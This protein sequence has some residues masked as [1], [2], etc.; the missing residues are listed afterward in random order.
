MSHRS[1][2]PLEVDRVPGAWKL[3]EAPSAVVVVMTAVPVPTLLI[4]KMYP[5]LTLLP[6]VTETAEGLEDVAVGC[7]V[8]FVNTL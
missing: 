6:N 3:T 7:V 1:G 4:W 5:S 8:L 2:V